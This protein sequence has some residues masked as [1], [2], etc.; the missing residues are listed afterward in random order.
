MLRHPSLIPLSHQ[1]QHGLAL[2]VRIER[3]L[4]DEALRETD[5]QADDSTKIRDLASRVSDMYDIE[6]RNHFEV[7]EKILFPAIL[8]KLGPMPLVDELV[9][10][11]RKIEKQV[12]ATNSATG[13]ADR[14]ERLLEFAA[15]LGAH[16]RRE[17]RE[18][19]EDIQKRLPPEIMD[20]L[21]QAIN[22][23]VVKVCL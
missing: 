10:E 3:G 21:A 11:H 15:M 4:R 1:H 20:A 6:L 18:L 9:A 7:E 8:E 17:E 5:A 12:E 22:S 19:F 16:I 23:A 2:C 13:S 14:R